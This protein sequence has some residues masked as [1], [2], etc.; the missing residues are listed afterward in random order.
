[1]SEQRERPDDRPLD[2]SGAGFS[3]QRCPFCHDAVDAQGEVWTACQGC[4][5][6]HHEACW[7]E[8]GRCGSCGSA[9]SLVPRAP[10]AA[11]TPAPQTGPSRPRAA[12]VVAAALVGALGAVLLP[13]VASEN[14]A[15]LVILA[16]GPAATIAMARLGRTAFWASGL[17]FLIHLA[18]AL[19]FL[20]SPHGK[21]E[22]AALLAVMGL[23]N[24]IVGR[25][26]LSW[27]GEDS[28]PP[29]FPTRSRP[30]PSKG[31]PL[32]K[33]ADPKAD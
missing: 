3:G 23:V 16:G 14:T 7:S 10:Q 27:P 11:S 29:A 13:G 21:E 28:E 18:T 33:G 19:L 22:G 32:P 25:V 12:G 15:L 31:P 6:R 4:L 5:A 9:A 20:L 30:Q 2:L 26:A 17:P 24:A 8:N 1:M